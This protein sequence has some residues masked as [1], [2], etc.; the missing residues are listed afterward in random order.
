MRMPNSI[1]HHFLLS[2]QNYRIFAIFFLFI[3]NQK[4]FKLNFFFEILPEKT[5][6][7]TKEKYLLLNETK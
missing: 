7:L 4:K 1:F 5:N 6:A 2:K 3:Q